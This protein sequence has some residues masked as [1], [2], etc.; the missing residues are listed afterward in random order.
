MDAIKIK[1]NITNSLQYLVVCLFE[2]L[3]A[4][5]QMVAKYASII[6]HEFNDTVLRAVLPSKPLSV[7][8][9]ILEGTY[10]HRVSS[11]YFLVC[12]SFCPSYCQSAYLIVLSV[13]PTVCFSTCLTVCLYRCM[14]VCLTVCP[15]VRLSAVLIFT[16]QVLCVC[17][18]LP[19]RSGPTYSPQPHSLSI[20]P[21][22]LFPSPSTYPRLTLL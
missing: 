18:I 13:C 15:S 14:Y 19:Y 4:E 17:R 21:V 16:S 8:K 5:Q 7:L 22:S 2:K 12:L 1:A 3:S 10:V 20:N 11:C 6:G 9:E